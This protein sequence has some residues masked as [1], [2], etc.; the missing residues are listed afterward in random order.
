MIAANEG[1]AVKGPWRGKATALLTNLQQ[2]IVASKVL[3]PKLSVRL[4]LEK[5]AWTRA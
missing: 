1:C 5:W 2:Q 3:N 4:V